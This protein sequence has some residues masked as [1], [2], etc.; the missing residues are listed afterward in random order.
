MEWKGGCDSGAV[1]GYSLKLHPVSASIMFIL[2]CCV[3]SLVDCQ[4]GVGGLGYVILRSGKARGERN[5]GHFNRRVT[6]PDGKRS[7]LTRHF[8][9]V[10]P[11]D[12]A[13]HSVVKTE[14]FSG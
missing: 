9:F 13:I 8:L 10:S 14:K 4:I 7:N 11:L 6:Q 12:S 5:A 1:I 3:N 2:K